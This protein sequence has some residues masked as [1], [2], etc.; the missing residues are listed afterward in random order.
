MAGLAPATIRF[1]VGLGVSIW[2]K[3]RGSG[4]AFGPEKGSF[5][6]KF[7]TKFGT[8]S[9]FRLASAVSGWT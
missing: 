5:L 8:K 1:E 3:Y 4:R 9:R 7:G 2:L 6:Q